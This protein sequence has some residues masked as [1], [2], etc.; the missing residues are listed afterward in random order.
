MVVIGSFDDRN[1]NAGLTNMRVKME[2]L[3]G[4]VKMNITEGQGKA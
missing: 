3:G 1:K 4:E 2:N